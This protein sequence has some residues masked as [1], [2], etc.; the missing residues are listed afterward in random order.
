[1]RSSG[2]VKTTLLRFL[3]GF[4]ADSGEVL[5]DGRPLARR[6]RDRGDERGRIQYVEAAARQR[7]RQRAHYQSCSVPSASRATGR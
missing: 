2:C 5:L 7:S 1:L 4:A 3:A 6:V